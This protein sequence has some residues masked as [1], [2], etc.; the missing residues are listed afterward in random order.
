MIKEL[1]LK[2]FRAIKEIKLENLSHVNVLCGKNNAGK[3]TI[4]EAICDNKAC[5]PGVRIK[6]EHV[7]L[8][9][10]AFEPIA[11]N[12][13]SP[14]PNMSIPW[15]RNKL[16]EKLDKVV[17]ADEIVGIQLLWNDDFG[18]VSHYGNNVF[19]FDAILSRFLNNET[20]EFRPVLI[21]PNRMLATTSPLDLVNKSAG[22]TE[23]NRILNRLFF[24]ST[25]D[26]KSQEFK[27]IE[28]IRQSFQEVTGG[29]K[30][31]ISIKGDKLVI[32][33][34]NASGD[35]I[36]ADASG[37]GLRHI[38]IIL[39]YLLDSEHS[40]ILVEE[41]ENHL[42]PDMQR[43]LLRL[44]SKIDNKQLFLTT[45]SNIF[46]D[47]TYVDKAFYV[48]FKDGEIRCY[49]KTSRTSMLTNLGY[50]AVDNLVADLIIFTEG[51]LDIPVINEICDKLGF[52]HKFSIK[53]YPLMGD[54]MHHLDLSLF[55]ERSKVMAI[56]DSDPKSG[57]IRK[58]FID[59][60][61]ENNISVTK[62]ERCAIENYFSL[63]AIRA[64]YLYQQI[65]S[66][67]TTL[68]NNKKVSEQLGFSVK[69][70]SKEIAKEMT[71]EEFEGTDLL[72]FCRNVNKVLIAE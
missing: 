50:S 57:H 63:R 35:W 68:D 27:I 7:S 22:Q 55:T 14:S 48:E 38:L 53:L 67:V 4:V 39:S 45:H 62:L 43:R 20:K 24:L 5:S 56:V 70:K 71:L 10:K 47:S 61:K 28:N 58:E 72:E 9:V 15:F 54:I 16:K 6:D 21:S 8:L 26:N 40:L 17:F 11:N 18:K 51:V 69:T 65:P 44:F 34:Q 32:Q 3:T 66:E 30:F 23:N 52:S 12:F 49:D 64:V 1:K 13:S 31:H 19:K 41:P 59:K 25:Q 36:D 60:C 37:L 42:H 29:F 46:L 2:E 33:F